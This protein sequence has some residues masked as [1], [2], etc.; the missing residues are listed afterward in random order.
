VENAAPQSPPA[1]PSRRWVGP[2]LVLLVFVVP[3]VLVIWRPWRK[4]DPQPEPQ[5]VQKPVRSRPDPRLTFATPYKNVRPEVKYVGDATCAGCH[6]RHSTTYS[7]HPMGR[8][9]APVATASPIERYDPPAHN[10]FDVGGFKYRV[11]PRG[12]T[13]RHVETV[14]NP[15]GQVIAETA[16]EV[17]FAVGSGHNGRAYLID[18]DGFLFASPITWYPLKGQW[19]LSPGYDAKRNPHFGRPITADC[20]FCHA[21]HADHVADST[22][23]YREPIF[24]GHAIGCERCHGP[25]ELHVRRREATEKFEGPDDTIVNP[26]KLEPALRESVCQQ[27]HLQ[28]RARVWRRGCETFD[29]RPGLPFHLFMSEFV[30]PAKDAAGA[31][32]VGSVEQMY[33]STCFR[34]STGANKLGCISCH[35]P[36]AL[37]AP[38]QKVAF[39]RGRCLKCHN[40]KAEDKEAQKSPACALPLPARLEKQDNCLTCHVPPTGSNVNHTT[41]SDHRIPRH[42][43]PPK[44][45][46]DS[47]P[48]GEPTLSHF[49]ADLL[50]GPD[51]ETDRDLGIALMRV[52][53]GHPAADVK[54]S[55]A[56][57]AVP[58]LEAAAARDDEDLPAL[59]ARGTALWTLGQLDAAAADYE[60][61]LAKAPERENTLFLAAKLA[62]MLGRIDAGRSYAERAVR[63]NPWRW[64]YHQALAQ[65]CAQANDW[66]GAMR[67]CQEVFKLHAAEPGT[68]QL[69]VVCYLK[70]GDRPQAQREFDTLMGL[71]PP[72][73]EKLRAWFAQQMR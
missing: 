12:Q 68:R 5:P 11:E 15:G 41:I 17:R 9:L 27:C 66:P 58:L 36:H 21:N 2:L 63:A 42:A 57:K 53:D 64:Q 14:T 70:L 37:P 10:P 29:F 23:R 34:K 59:E 13:A 24:Q 16:A 49:H 62:Q 26:G 55:L 44:P 56:A 73:A 8:S 33:A 28:G 52:A 72:D 6:S 51:P 50:A 48:P 45:P 18:H 69:L 30:S 46:P 61:V 39:Y 3:G 25:G 38:E 22:N 43:E 7:Q 47:P 4:P 60:R 20:L 65:A 71:N 67:E 40:E 31:K 32:F 35:D 19:D 54:R 1:E